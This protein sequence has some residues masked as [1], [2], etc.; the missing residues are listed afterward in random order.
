MSAST[1][2]LIPNGPGYSTEDW[3]TSFV[4]KAG[5][6]ALTP[7]PPNTHTHGFAKFHPIFPLPS[8]NAQNT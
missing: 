7:R 3:V 4:V 5:L 6:E 2:S 8:E 1:N